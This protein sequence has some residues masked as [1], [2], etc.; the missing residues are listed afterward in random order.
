MIPSLLASDSVGM[1]Y[2][3]LNLNNNPICVLSVYMCETQKVTEVRNIGLAF[4]EAVWPQLDQNQ[5]SIV[6]RKSSMHTKFQIILSIGG[7]FTLPPVWESGLCS[8][9]LLKLQDRG[10]IHAYFVVIVWNEILILK[11]IWIVPRYWYMKCLSIFTKPL[12]P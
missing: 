3:R 12:Q 5:N 10:D 2:M 11:S 6:L 1:I 9:F 8:P 7:C 4:I